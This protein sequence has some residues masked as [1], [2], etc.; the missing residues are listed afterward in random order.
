MENEERTDTKPELED[1]EFVPEDD[2]IIGRAFRWSLLVIVLL[3]AGIGGSLLLSGDRPVE[4][5][6]REI[7]TRA[8]D[9]L[10][11]EAEGMPH[12]R[13]VDITRQAG[14]DFSHVNGAT[15]EKLLPETMGGGVAFIDYNNSGHPDLLFVNSNH[16]P[17]DSVSGPRAT[18]KL[19]R[20]DGRGN[21]TDVTRDAGLDVSFY[22]MGVAVG[23]YDNDGWDD[24]YITAVGRNYLFRNNQ[25]RFED[26]TE[27]T[28][29]AG[30]DSSWSTGAGFFDYNNN[31]LL[32][33]FVCNYLEWSK[34]IDF[35]IGFTLNGV[36]RAYGPPTNFSGAH[37]YLFRNNGDG[38]FTD[39]SAETG[40]QVTN[41]ATGGPL[42]K[43]LA[44]LPI[45]FDRDGWID[46]VVA[47]DTVQNFLFHNQGDGTFREIGMEAGVAFDFN[48]RATGAMGIDAGHFRND[49][50]MAIGIGNFANEM[51]SLFLSQ[52]ETLWFADES[53]GEGLGSPS[54]LSLTF[55]FFFFDYDLDGRLDLLQ[56][57]GHL[58]EE[59]NQVQSSQHYRQPAQLFWNA[60]DEG[61]STFVEV[62]GETTGDLT[63]AIVGRAAAFAD[64]DGDGDLDVV[65]TQTGGPP[66]L[67]RNDQQLGHNFIRFKLTGTTLNRNA[68][69]AWIEVVSGDLVQRRPVLPTRSYLSQV[70]MPVT[71]GLGSRDRIDSIVVTWPNGQEQEATEFRLNSMNIIE[72]ERK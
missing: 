41:P 12:V 71:F 37:S 17:W 67:L 33:L 22:G 54:R 11:Q 57:N 9:R 50:I 7:E 63:T 31:G 13:F 58:E 62:P 34:E 72:Q 59:I 56:A 44:I 53:I 23:D 29:V 19:Y 65:L 8:P 28:E 32:D 2:A 4:E 21:F 20:N 36:D 47:N 46:I 66:L 48:G 10:I 61:T 5:V 64:I 55:G 14:I 60:G 42:A 68:I 15:G 49:D 30:M 40:I 43:A 1:E 38:T 52:E 24:L 69:G 70:E 16:W 45:D 26:V 3:A 51:S 39:V 6:V 27:R 35:R 25:G 18:M